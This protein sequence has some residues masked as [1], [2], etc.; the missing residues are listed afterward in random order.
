MSF[1]Y[2]KMAVYSFFGE[3]VEC[4]S[5]AKTVEVKEVC[6]KPAFGNVL[7]EK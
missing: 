3:S 6:G 5:H 4:E 7:Y 2:L 1:A